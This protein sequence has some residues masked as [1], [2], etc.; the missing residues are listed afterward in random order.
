[1]TTSI[2][3]SYNFFVDSER[4]FNGTS[5]GDNITFSFNQ[6]PI[7]CADNQ[8]IRLS[9]Q[10]F[11]MYKSFTNI[12]INNNIFRIT[13]DASTPRS[14]Y[15]VY[16]PPANYRKLNALSLAY[17]TALA[18]QLVADIGGG[19]TYTIP[20]PTLFPK[21]AGSGDNIISYTIDF[22]SPHGL[23]NLQI[24]T[25]VSDGDS[26]EVL[27]TNRIRA[28]DNTAAWDLLNSTN[29]DLSVAN[30]ITITSLYN[31]QLSSQQNVYLRT[32]LPSTNIQTESFT[33]ANEDII[34][35]A[36]ISSSNI[37]GRMIIDDEFVN[38]NTGTSDEYQISLTSRQLTHLRIYITDSH[39]RSIPQNV[40][41]VNN[42]PVST[43]QRTLGNRS[44][45][46]VI[47]FE[48]IQYSGG[49]NNRL[50]TAPKSHSVSAH[51]GSRPYDFFSTGKYRS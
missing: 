11:S 36:Q 21:L 48:I 29:V 5:D 1:M 33:S 30:A 40:K 4:C 15:P 20:T 24:R 25:L 34:G 22:S 47:K 19:I 26:F 49:Q 13:H 44:F 46:A 10:S 9:L 8:F 39:G 50:E 18:N 41:Y 42:I 14:D 27:G 7:T 12:N 6:T 32:D 45:E 43:N 38:F 3:N 16:I 23:T 28:D 51:Y 31:G 37:I 2:Q 35:N 17:A